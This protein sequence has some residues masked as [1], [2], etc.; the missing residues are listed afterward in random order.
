M[1][2]ST[3][4]CEPLRDDPQADEQLQQ[5]VVMYLAHADHRSMRSLA[6][7]ARNGVVTLCGTVP[8]FYVRQLAIACASRVAGVRVVIDQ[9]E[10]CETSQQREM[11][12]PR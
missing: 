6:V 5:R 9:V 10:A 1:N 7:T 3:R 2:T 4:I 12:R 8:T 11:A